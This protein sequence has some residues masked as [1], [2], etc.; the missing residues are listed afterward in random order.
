[1]LGWSSNFQILLADID[2]DGKLDRKEFYRLM[3][4]IRRK[5]EISPE[6]TDGGGDQNS[7]EN[8]L[9]DVADAEKYRW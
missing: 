5:V 6:S 3:C 8:Y 1:M 9:N 2:N 4:N 7:V